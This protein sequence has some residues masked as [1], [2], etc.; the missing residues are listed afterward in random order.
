MSSS[1]VTTIIPTTSRSTTPPPK[2][3]VAAVCPGAP[4]RIVK[5]V[6]QPLS[7]RVGDKIDFSNMDTL[8]ISRQISSMS[9]GSY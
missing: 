1:G 5:P 4:L 7:G 9:L 6:T 2:A 3:K 8:S